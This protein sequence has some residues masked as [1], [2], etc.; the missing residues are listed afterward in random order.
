MFH[1]WDFRILTTSFHPQSNQMIERFHH[2]LKS[3]LHVRL[4]GSNWVSHLPLV[5]LSLQSSPK[6]DSGFSPA[7]AV[8]GTPLSLPS[9]FLE[10]LELPLD[11]FLRQVE[12]AVPGFSGPPR[13][14]V[15]P[16]PQPQ[17]LPRALLT[18]EYMFV[19]DDAS[20]PSLS[21]LYSGPYKIYWHFKTFLFSKSGINQLC[22]CRQ[23]EACHLCYSCDSG[24]TSSSWMAS[25]SSIL[26]LVTSGSCSSSG[27]ES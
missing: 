23:A 11:V 15:T 21:P 9:N 17:P 2:S 12:R 19:C 4:A 24:C 26:S 22:L 1:P 20:K 18:A 25:S 6:D 27:E 8:Y 14:H 5:M 13:Q 16:Q 7:E 10:H 3:S